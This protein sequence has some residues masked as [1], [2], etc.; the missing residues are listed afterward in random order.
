MSVRTPVFVIC[1]PLERVGK[2]LI[3]RLLAEFFTSDDRPVECF[4][5]NSD[6]PSLA[7]YLPDRT[8]V[9]ALADTRAQM[10]LFDRL[11]GDDGTAK[12]LDL[13]HGAFE[14]FFTV[15]AQVRFGEEALRRGV[16]VVLLFVASPSP[17]AA[18]AYATLLRWLPGVV[19]VPVHNEVLGRALARDKYPIASGASLPLRIPVLA[20]GLHRIAVHQGFSFAAFRAR[21]FQDI[22]TSYQ[23]ELESW[24]KRVF[25][26]FREL[27][28]RLLLAALRLSLQH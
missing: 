21:R 3:A 17:V 28:L 24:M 13:G 10:A 16:Q 5:L 2:T 8:A 1:S 11:I 19:L 12:V 4:D 23:I 9:A 27:E 7:D 14:Q 18:Q 25:V 6:R 20:P 26:E 15:S 22:S